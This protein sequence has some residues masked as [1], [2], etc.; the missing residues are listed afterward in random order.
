ML[1][2]LA[3]GIVIIALIYWVTTLLPLPQPAPKILQVLFIII[4]ILYILQ[5]FGLLGGLSLK[6]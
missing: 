3:V 6:V 2:S 4:L 5:A 1:I